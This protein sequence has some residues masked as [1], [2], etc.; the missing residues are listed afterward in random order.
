MSFSVKFSSFR[1]ATALASAALVMSTQAGIAPAMAADSSIKNP[2]RI[3]KNF[4]PKNIGPVLSDLGIVWQERNTPDGKSF[5]AASV[6]ANFSFSIYPAACLEDGGKS[7]CVGTHYVAMYRGSKPNP[8]TVTSF[9]QAF[10]FT[11]AGVT[12]NGSAFISRYEIAD[13]GIPRGNIASS[14]ASFL[15]LAEVF[16]GEL[17]TS[18]KTV[19]EQGYPEDMSARY[20]NG[21]GAQGMGVATNP[22]SNLGAIHRIAFDEAVNVVRIL[23]TQDAA[24]K[25]KITNINQ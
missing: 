2:S 24:P 9:N 12:Q 23:E 20:L 11:S 10:P 16:Q 3:V 5:I 1:P 25:N 22:G 19:A 6:G 4:D 18:T 7:N 13:Y 8:Q 14:L 15:Y 17:T 21:R